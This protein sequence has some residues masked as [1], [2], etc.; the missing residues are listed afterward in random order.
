MKCNKKRICCIPFDKIAYYVGPTGPKGPKGEKGDAGKG[1]QIDGTYKDF[2]ELPK[3]PI[4][5][6][7]VLMGEDN[8]RK[9][10][11]YDAKTNQWIDDGFLQGEKGEKGDAGEK[12]ERGE[13]GEK[14]DKGDDGLSYL[15][16]AY[17]VTLNDTTLSVPDFGY[18][19]ASKE[20]LP[21]RK[22]QAST[23]NIIQLN[24]N[25][26][27]IQF[28]EI[29]TYEILFNFN[30]YMD[31]NGSQFDMNTD[32]LSVGFRPVDADEVNIGVNDWS[33]NAVPHN[34]TG[35]GIIEVQDL[36]TPYEL[37]NL[38]KSKDLYLLG[39]K[40]EN[41][42]TSSYFTSPMVTILIKKIK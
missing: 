17:L 31:L 21:I 34:V 40:K 15:K 4:D 41:T 16:E 36:V 23:S 37:V 22:I 10:Y 6:M 42:L 7:T 26:D 28:N 19:V 29:G 27:T 14:G 18:K 3:T 8:P 33:F 13:K 12:G 30:G 5:G 2:D 25:E 9:I 24:A 11:I 1:I 39:A 20:R 32:F 35:M 38:H